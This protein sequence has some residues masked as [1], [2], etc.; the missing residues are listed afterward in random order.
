MDFTSDT[1]VGASR[2]EAII[3]SVAELGFPG[4]PEELATL[5]QGYDDWKRRAD[6]YNIPR[7]NMMHNYSRLA[8]WRM[9]HH[10]F[11]TQDRFVNYFVVF[12]PFKKTDDKNFDGLK[13][14]RAY[15]KNK[16]IV[17]EAII[18]TREVMAKRVHY[19]M[20]ISTMYGMC[21]LHDK[22]TSKYRMHV[23]MILS[24]IK[25]VLA[26]HDYIV[27]ESK[28]RYFHTKSW[29]GTS[30]TD[31]VDLYC[32]VGNTIYHNSLA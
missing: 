12:K 21:Q 17:A 11:E 13:H 5:I 7:Y 3:G 6:S 4:T 29:D 8:S 23:Q 24:K 27:K 31:N 18:I 10:F 14:I 1:T 32:R 2:K 19:N 15:L 20:L 28:I 16:G 30:Y 22:Q 26:I 25:P 9:L